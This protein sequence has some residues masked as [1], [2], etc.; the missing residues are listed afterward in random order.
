VPTVGE[1]RAAVAAGDD[2]ELLFTLPP[3][4]EDRVDA[5]AAA[6]DVAL[7][8]IGRIVEEPGVVLLDAEGDPLPRSDGGW[9]HFRDA[10]P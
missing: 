9:D 3:S 5:L 6:G 4:A 8:R 1:A 7:A 2:Y 10:G